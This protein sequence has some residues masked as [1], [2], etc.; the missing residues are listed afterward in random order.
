[1]AN[2]T[3]TRHTEAAHIYGCTNFSTIQEEGQMSS[4]VPGAPLDGTIVWD[5][6]AK[7]GYSVTISDFDVTNATPHSTILNTWIN[8]PSPVH[9][10]EM[11]QVSA[12]L[13][14]ITIYLGDASGSSFIMPNND[15]NIALDIEGCARLAGEPIRVH[16]N[17]PGDSNTV[18]SVS[19][20]KDLTSNLTTN[21]IS[22]GNDEVH[23]TLDP[24]GVNEDRGNGTY[25]MSYNVSAKPGYRYSYVPLLSFKDN[26]YYTKRRVTTSFNEND[27]TND[28]ISVSFDIYKK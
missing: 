28:V 19:I 25:L 9:K 21:E 7:P 27:G 16:V 6:K 15:I 11:E 20:S 12:I 26:N 2:Y 10:V 14:R 17:K 22:D 3:I 23:G 13:I 1:M 24:R 5:L 4:V 8:T 18:T